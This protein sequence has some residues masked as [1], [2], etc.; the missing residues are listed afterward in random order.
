MPKKLTYDEVYE[1]FTKCGYVLKETEYINSR[2]K[3]RYICPE[4]P[5][6]ETFI[7]VADLNSG[8]RCPF[9]SGVGRNKF[10]TI[11]KEF[12]T[13]GYTLL[14]KDYINNRTKMPFT[15]SIHPEEIQY[16]KYNSFSSGRGC[17]FCGIESRSSKKRLP[18]EIVKKAFDERGYILL[19]STYKNSKQKLKYIC[20]NH[21][22]KENYITYSDLQN[23]VGC[24]YCVGLK[25]Y[26]IEEV[27]T[28]FEENNFTLLDTEYVNSISPLK[29]YCNIHSNI[30]QYKSLH[31]FK[32]GN[33]CIYCMGKK[34]TF[35][36][37]FGNN[38]PELLKEW[39]YFKNN[40]DP[41]EVLP[42]SNKF[43]WWKCNEC[44]YEWNTRIATRTDKHSGCPKCAETKGE[45]R[46]R[47][48]LEG[49]NY[50]FVPQYEFEDLKGIKNGN[51]SYDF[52][53]PKLNILIEYQ[54]EFHD[55]SGSSGYT[56]KNLKRQQ[57]H[58]RRKREY[59][60]QNG[61]NL[62]EIWYYDFNKIEEILENK[63]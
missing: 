23:G 47:Y 50:L 56:K 31:L 18:Y 34:A 46:I 40:I 61:I 22:D 27:K 14:A 15:C 11:K 58:D 12:E 59:A 55:G 17:R 49:R 29:C 5:N 57:E 8:I 26:T 7:R 25:K 44:E 35:D 52:Y 20:P 16:I 42:K 24:A 45:K 41:Y 37:S 6:E 48:Y 32:Q 36:T 51:L 2:T 62:I 38:Y 19:D 33:K 60:K 43:V 13:K 10:E 30:I 63:L 21:P 1:L 54:G 4:H 53:L 9:C 28:I 39:D 3:M